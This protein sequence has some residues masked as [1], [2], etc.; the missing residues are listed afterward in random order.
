MSLP[1][2]LQ[3]RRDEAAERL[4]LRPAHGRGEA[5]KYTTYRDLAQRSLASFEWGAAGFELLDYAAAMARHPERVSASLGE[6]AS[7]AWAD[8]SLAG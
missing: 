1:A 2:W 3:N 6:L 8:A 4:A 5:N 7:G